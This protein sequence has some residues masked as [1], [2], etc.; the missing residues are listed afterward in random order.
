[1][2]EL[3]S[4]CS[5]TTL[6]SVSQEIIPTIQNRLQFI[7]QTRPEWWV[8]TIYWQAYTEN[9]NN[10]NGIVLSCCDGHFRGP[11][12]DVAAVVSKNCGSQKDETTTFGFDFEIMKKKNSTT[13]SLFSQEEEMHVDRE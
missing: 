8:Y 10:H 6:V 2:E 1:M 12:K 11:K 5:S 7:I 3:T 13:T 9:K 4:P